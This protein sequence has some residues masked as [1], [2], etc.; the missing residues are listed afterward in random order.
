MEESVFKSEGILGAGEKSGA[1]IQDKEGH[2]SVSWLKRL[3][4]VLTASFDGPFWSD[5][6]EEIGR[7]WLIGPL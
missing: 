6:T 5:W 1:G 7:H 2:E 4:Q 3:L